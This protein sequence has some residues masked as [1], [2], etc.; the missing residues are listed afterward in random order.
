MASSS[1]RSEVAGWEL[2]ASSESG[3][4]SAIWTAKA[5]GSKITIHWNSG[6]DVEDT[7]QSVTVAIN[8]K[9]QFSAGFDWGRD[10]CSDG[11]SLSIEGV[12]RGANRSYGS[13]SGTYRGDGDGP[14]TREL[15]VAFRK[16]LGEVELTP[17][18][19][20]ALVQTAVPPAIFSRCE[21]AVRI[22]EATDV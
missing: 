9:A 13:R 21:I 14:V 18:R 1:L 3:A 17:K 12:G 22:A 10:S 5:S 6:S 4:D 15:T 11:Y 19:L 8:D 2:S 16:L 7:W 20:T